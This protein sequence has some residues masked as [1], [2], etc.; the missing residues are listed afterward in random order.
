MKPHK[1]EEESIS[2]TFSDINR[3]NVSL[4]QSHLKIDNKSKNKQ[5]G[6]NKTDKRLHSKGNYPQNQNKTQRLWEKCLQTIRPTRD[7]SPKYINSACGGVLVAKS[8]PTL[9]NPTDCNLLGSSVHGDSPGKNTGVGRH[10]LC[11]GIFPTQESNP[12][13]HHC[14]QILYWLSHQGR[15]NNSYN[16]TTTKT[17]SNNAQKTNADI[18]TKR[19]H[20]WSSG[21]WKYAQHW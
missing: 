7:W 17:Q 9:C 15:L 20:R 4:G 6:P 8:F 3:I 10:F 14:R 16:S 13:L 19:T 12:G 5:M 11:Q 21:E 2:E 1:L 18:S